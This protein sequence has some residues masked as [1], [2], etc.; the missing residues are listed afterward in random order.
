[1]PVSK[2]R[3][4]VAGLIVIVGVLL[5][6]GVLVIRSGQATRIAAIPHTVSVSTNSQLTIETIPPPRRPNRALLSTIPAL[7]FD[8]KQGPVENFDHLGHWNRDSWVRYNGLDFGTGVSS[9]VVVLSCGS[10]F[11]GRILQ[12]RSDSQNGPIIAEVVVP[13]TKGFEAHTAP[14]S[15]VTGIHDLFLTCNDGGFNLQSLK[16]LRPQSATNVIAATSYSAFNGIK[17][18]RPGVV[19]HTDGGDWLKYDEIDFGQGVSRVALDLAMG[20]KDAMVE[21]HLDALDGPLIGTLIPQPT[22]SW[23]TFRIQESPVQSATGVHNLYLTFEG[24]KGLPDV[25]TIQFNR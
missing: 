12:L 23:T 19:G 15:G 7:T 2:Q 16:F 9:V 11:V 13:E 18:P 10:Q 6:T 4:I 17:E 20:A 3:Q 24:G 5:M 1:M 8:E 14:I 22:G 25:R 21:F